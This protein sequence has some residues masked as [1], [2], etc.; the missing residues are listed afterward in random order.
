MKRILLKCFRIIT[1]FGL[2]PFAL[3][4]LRYLPRYIS[5]LVKW[6]KQGGKIDQFAV[7]LTN[8]QEPAGNAES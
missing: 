1:F 4:S 6:K 2:N 8:Y 5:D 3:L 7:R